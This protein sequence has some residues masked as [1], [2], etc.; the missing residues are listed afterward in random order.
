MCFLVLIAK[1]Q[2]SL[3]YDANYDGFGTGS[4]HWPNQHEVACTLAN[5]N[6][7]AGK[8][9]LVKHHD[10]RMVLTEKGACKLLSMKLM[11]RQLY[12]TVHD[13]RS[14]IGNFS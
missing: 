4:C 13:M 14:I 3:I 8:L 2:D 12:L 6:F 5:P 7:L 1:G 9:C 11:P 10:G